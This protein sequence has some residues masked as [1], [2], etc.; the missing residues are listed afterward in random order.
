[1]INFLSISMYLIKRKHIQNYLC[2]LIAVLIAYFGL[3][4][5]V[6]V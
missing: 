1:M 2:Y 4:T 5:V 6:D 3:I